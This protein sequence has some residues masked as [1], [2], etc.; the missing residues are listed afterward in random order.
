MSI[1]APILLATMTGARR[2]E[3]V[4][5]TW[6]DVGDGRITFA[7]AARQVGRELTIGDTKNRKVRSVAIGD[8]AAAELRAWKREQAQQLLR[9]GIRQSTA[10]PVCTRPDGQRVEPNK[11][12]VEFWRLA[13]RLGVAVHFHSLRHSHATQ[14]LAAGLPPH[15]AQE[16]LGHHSAAFTLDRYAG[17][18]KRQRDDAAAKVDAIFQRG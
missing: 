15:V 13:R 1:Y 10:T 2:G 5:L 11:L 3:C 6:K 7:H 9:L 16:R 17:V 12:T 8:N 14:I 18:L 4:A